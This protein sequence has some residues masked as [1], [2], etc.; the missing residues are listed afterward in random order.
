MG[1]CADLGEWIPFSSAPSGQ[2][3]TTDFADL[4]VQIQNVNEP[5]LGVSV[6][7]A[8]PLSASSGSVVT[9]LSA[10]DEDVGSS[11]MYTIVA[12]NPDGIF[13]LSPLGVV[14]VS[15][16]SVRVFCGPQEGAL[17]WYRGP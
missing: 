17:W 15:A 3:P 10:S 14:T 16:A 1:L 6:T 5:P 8:M 7:V 2:T 12:G 11:L 4:R 13:A 9:T